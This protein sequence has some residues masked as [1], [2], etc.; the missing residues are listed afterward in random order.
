MYEQHAFTLVAA[1]KASE[2]K[3][4][5]IKNWQINLT[6][7]HNDDCS[8]IKSFK[9]VDDL[10]S[11]RDIKGWNIKLIPDPL[12]RS[13]NLIPDWNGYWRIDQIYITQDILNFTNSCWIDKEPRSKEKP[14]DH[15][16]V[17]V[18]ISWPPEELEKEARA[19]L[20]LAYHKV[21]RVYTCSYTF[22]VKW[23]Y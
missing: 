5:A 19:Q 15:A 23:V 4:K 8:G 2:A 18:N 9:Q 7:K 1:K 14:S 10:H 3:K 6:K 20:L 16:P 22:A 11:I 17:I 21:S 13:D 12:E